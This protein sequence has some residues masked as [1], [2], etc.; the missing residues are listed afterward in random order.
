M[1][2]FTHQRAPDGDRYTPSG[3]IPGIQAISRRPLL[4]YY[5][6]PDP[7]DVN[8]KWKGAPHQLEQCCANLRLLA[9]LLLRASSLWADQ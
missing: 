9:V 3:M 2:V 5:S 8:C 7:L 6:A 4:D 1:A